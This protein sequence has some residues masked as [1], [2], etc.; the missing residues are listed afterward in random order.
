M[1][2]RRL[3]PLLA[4]A[5]FA[6]AGAPIATATQAA[7]AA[8]PQAVTTVYYDASQAPDLADNVTEAVQIWNDSVQNVRLVAGSPADVTISEGYG[9]GSYTIPQGLGAGE[10]YLDLQQAQEYNPTRIV[11]HELGHIYGLPDNYDGDCSILMS[12]HSAGY[13]CQTTHPSAAEA[14]QVDANFADGIRT[15]RQPAVYHGCFDR[16]PAELRA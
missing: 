8:T 12:G 6:L 9:G 11:A 13:D 15:A 10:V 7:A 14:A 16:A 4:V 2:R 5:L 3:V 1:L